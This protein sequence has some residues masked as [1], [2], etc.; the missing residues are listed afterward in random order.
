M[1]IIDRV[2]RFEDR[3]LEEL[4]SRKE[5]QAKLALAAGIG[6]LLLAVLEVGVGLLTDERSWLWIAGL[7]IVAGSLSLRTWRRLRDPAR[8]PDG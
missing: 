5:L 6:F 4:R 7:Q 3:S 8:S 2:R 1:G